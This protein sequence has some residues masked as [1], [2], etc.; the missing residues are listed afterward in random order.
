LRPEKKIFSRVIQ[1]VKGFYS[2]LPQ[3]NPLLDRSALFAGEKGRSDPEKLYTKIEMLV[4]WFRHHQASIFY[5]PGK[6]KK[7][8]IQFA[9]GEVSVQPSSCCCC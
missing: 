7:G 6:S 5:F 3:C 4:C 9:P 2:E 8:V 1:W